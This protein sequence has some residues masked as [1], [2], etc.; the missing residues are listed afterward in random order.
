MK[1]VQEVQFGTQ[2]DE[3]FTKS[4]TCSK[5]ELLWELRVYISKAALP[6]VTFPLTDLT[7][8][9]SVGMMQITD[10]EALCALVEILVYTLDPASGEAEAYFKAGCSMEGNCECTQSGLGYI[11]SRVGKHE[12]AISHFDS[13][14]KLAQTTPKYCFGQDLP[15]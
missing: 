5:D 7:F 6:F 12:I 8:D 9:K 14:L 4:L 13:A 2:L 11:A 3:A 10:N 1:Y 15:V